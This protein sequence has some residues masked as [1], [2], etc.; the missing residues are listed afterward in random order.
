L[1]IRCGFEKAASSPSSDDDESEDG[2]CLFF[3]V[4]LDLLPLELSTMSDGD[5]SLVNRELDS[6]PAFFRIDELLLDN[7]E[8]D[9]GGGD[10]KSCSFCREFSLVEPLLSLPIFIFDAVKVLR[11]KDAGTRFDCRFGDA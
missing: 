5:E 9:E 1:R 6:V 7:D 8:V 3:V 10:D 2:N 11:F 4:G